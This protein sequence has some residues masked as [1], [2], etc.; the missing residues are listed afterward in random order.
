MADPVVRWSDIPG[1]PGRATLRA[2]L[3]VG[4]GGQPAWLSFQ[5]GWGEGDE[6]APN[7][8]SPFTVSGTHVLGLRD[9]LDALLGG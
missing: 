9:A 8:E 5:R 7:A 6:F 4:P 2:S 1:G 3:D